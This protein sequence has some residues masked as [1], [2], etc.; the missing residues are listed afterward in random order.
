M[1]NSNT[2][3]VR[4]NRESVSA[5][6][7]RR[8]LVTEGR[9]NR[10]TIVRCASKVLSPQSYSIALQQI[11]PPNRRVVERVRGLSY[12]CCGIPEKPVV[13][14]KLRGLAQG[15]DSRGFPIVPAQVHCERRGMPRLHPGCV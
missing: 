6:S 14:K 5:G 3:E 7:R 12:L 4:G 1:R 8:E 15:A 2:L 10:K 11:H 9:G 13:V